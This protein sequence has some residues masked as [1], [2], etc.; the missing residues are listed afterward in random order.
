MPL[1]VA[2]TPVG[3]SATLT[4]EHAPPPRGHPTSWFVLMSVATSLPVTGSYASAELPRA[5]PGALLVMIPAPVAFVARS[6]SKFTLPLL[7]QY[8]YVASA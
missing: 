4:V 5:M 3:A 1:C 7:P 2:T 6:I 8:R